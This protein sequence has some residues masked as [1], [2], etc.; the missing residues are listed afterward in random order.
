MWWLLLCSE[1]AFQDG[2]VAQAVDTVV[3]QGVTYFSAAG[4]EGRGAWEILNPVFAPT[5][6]NTLGTINALQFATGDATLNTFCT[7]AGATIFILH[8]N[9]PWFTA[10]GVQADLDM[11]LF[12][13]A[14]GNLV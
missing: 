14:N 11:Y 4:N 6:F 12:D 5:T 9:E 2:I 10:S 8:W 1:P 7:N 3:S 13:P